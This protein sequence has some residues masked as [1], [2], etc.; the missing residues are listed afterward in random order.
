MNETTKSIHATSAASYDSVQKV[1]EEE[2]YR[3]K[4]LAVC[5]QLADLI[6]DLDADPETSGV[7]TIQL[8]DWAEEAAEDED[9][10]LSTTEALCE[11]DTVVDVDAQVQWTSG[12]G[13]QWREFLDENDDIVAERVRRWAGS[14]AAEIDLT[15]A[16]WDSANA[17]SSR[18]RRECMV[19]AV[20]ML[21]DSVPSAKFL[22]A[23]ETDYPGELTY[24]H[25]LDAQGQIVHEMYGSVSDTDDDLALDE[26]FDDDLDSL[27]R[28]AGD[29]C[30]GWGDAVDAARSDFNS[31]E[32]SWESATIDIDALL[33]QG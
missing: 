30:D 3:V 2:L 28:G 14:N 27:V 7:T 29:L 26:S 33:A 20:R 24:A 8:L 21:R 15:E 32:G 19:A 6:A 10:D 12:D 16:L 5:R 23:T 9:Y 22:V 13:D 4:G 25:T 31:R 18:A 11:D 1:L 17:I